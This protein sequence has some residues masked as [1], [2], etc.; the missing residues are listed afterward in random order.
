[1]GFRGLLG[2]RLGLLVAM[3]VGWCALGRE[4]TPARLPGRLIIL[5]LLAVARLRR[6]G[7]APGGSVV[8][9]CPVSTLFLIEGV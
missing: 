1:M 8:V 2:L 6:G 5:G 4:L 9:A 7:N 3:V